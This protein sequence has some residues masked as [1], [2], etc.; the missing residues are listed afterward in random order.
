MTAA[1]LAALWLLA[2][3]VALISSD[4]LVHSLTALGAAVGMSAGL[5]GLLVA[6]GAD[7]PEV[8]SALI[9]LA[10]GQAD[11]GLGVVVGSNIYNL[12]GLL[13]LSALLAGAIWTGPHRLSLDGATSLIMTLLL[14]ALVLS[15]GLHQLLG[16]A[17]M[18]ALGLYSLAEARMSGSQSPATDAH[19]PAPSGQDDP[20]TRVR[21]P[22]LRRL[23][24]YAL[25]AA[26]GI[27]AGSYV[28][29]TTSIALG[30]AAGIP[31][32]IIGTF[33][34]PVTTSLPNTWAAVS[35]ARRGLAS[36]T[37]ATTFNS[38]SINAAIGTGLPSVFFAVHAS[39]ATRVIDLPWLVGM[40]VIALVLVAT[41][42]S[43]ARW[44]GTFLLVLYAA[45]VAVRLALFP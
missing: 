19:S 38:N 14:V 16:A 10:Q 37:I 33:V 36:A 25:A 3:A 44:E 22:S 29:V 4:R 23:V 21:R 17:L 8:T 31:S 42:S 5:L 28:L 18:V 43:L 24:L 1:G 39:H 11:I 6:L 34:L 9:A 41:R 20:L 30:P 45:F 27:I 12:A 7:G 2:L 32:S 15:P 40:T 13:G 35:L 26:A